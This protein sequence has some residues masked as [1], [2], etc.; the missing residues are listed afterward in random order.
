MSGSKGGHLEEN[1]ESMGSRPMVKGSH[2]MVKGSRPH[3]KSTGSKGSHPMGRPKGGARRPVGGDSPGP[4]SPTASLGGKST[5]SKGSHLAGKGIRRRGRNRNVLSANDPKGG[6][7]ESPTWSPRGKNPKG[8]QPEPR[9]P[10]RLVQ[11][12]TF[13]VQ[14]EILRTWWMIEICL[15]DLLNLELMGRFLD[16]GWLVRRMEHRVRLYRHPT[17]DVT[18]LSN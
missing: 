7:P 17:P 3:G 2:P 12:G 16:V 9:S 8:G 15:S 13:H 18:H 14:W 6:K 1:P 11:L 10:S 4:A 5:G